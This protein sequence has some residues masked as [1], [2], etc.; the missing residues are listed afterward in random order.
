MARTLE[1]AVGSTLAF[2]HGA[3]VRVF[4]PTQRPCVSMLFG[5]AAA[6]SGKQEPCP[7]GSIRAADGL[8]H[9]N[10]SMDSGAPDLEDDLV[11]ITSSLSPLPALPPS[12]TNAY[13]DDPAAIEFGHALFYEPSLSPSGEFPCVS[14]HDPEITFTDGNLTGEGNG[15]VARNALSI[16]DAEYYDWHLWDGGCDTIWCQATIPIEA[17]AEMDANRVELARTIYQ[18]DTLRGD[19]EAIFGAM[20]P[21]DDP[22]FPEKAKPEPLTPDTPMHDA[23]ESMT[24]GDKDAVNRVF[25]NLAKSLE[26]FQRTIV[27]SPSRFDQFAEAIAGGDRSGGGHMTE[28]ELRGFALYSGKAGCIQCHSGPFFTNQDFANTGLGARSW[29]DQIDTGRIEAA[30][31]IYENT[32][33]GVGPYSDDVAYAESFLD[34]LASVDSQ[35]GQFRVATLRNLEK[36]APYM[37]GGHF[38]TLA[39]VLSF[40]NE[41]DEDVFQG[42]RDPRLQ[43]LGLS[44]DELADLEAFLLALEGGP[45]DPALTMPPSR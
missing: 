12:P 6:C 9:L 37:H 36:T 1:K 10:E 22:R 5:I 39:E 7:P 19:Y 45:V 23:W 31:D 24:D 35:L 16:V 42:E 14:C 26:S 15:V 3:V 27:S 20:P 34:G 32:F 29:L 38:E 25:A 43:P 21:M 17:A 2:F 40:Y 18:N 30:E 41:L 11:S 44:G 33:S 13:A 4:G 8:C 28:A